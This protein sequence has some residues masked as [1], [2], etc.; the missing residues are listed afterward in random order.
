MSPFRDGGGRCPCR[1]FPE[2]SPNAARL[3]PEPPKSE[4]YIFRLLNNLDSPWTSGPNGTYKRLT[5]RE[6]YGRRTEVRARRERK[7]RAPHQ[8]TLWIQMFATRRRGQD[9]R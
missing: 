2:T 4:T 8:K 7:K 1:R 6:S 5:P 9:V 3:D